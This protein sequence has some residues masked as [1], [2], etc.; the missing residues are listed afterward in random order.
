MVIKSELL[1]ILEIHNFTP[2]HMVLLPS[3]HRPPWNQRKGSLHGS[4]LGP[5]NICYGC[6]SLSSSGTPNRGSGDCLWL[7][8]FLLR[9][10][11]F[12]CVALSSL[13]I[14]GIAYAMFGWYPLEVCSFLK[15]K[16]RGV[17][18]GREEKGWGEIGRRGGRGKFSWDVIYERGVNSKRL[19][20]KEKKM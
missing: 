11:Y 13:D 4:D 8:C 1:N 2:E 5:L 12:Y 9:L 16:G 6:S 14:R 7:F 15:G 18:V 19:K 10:F 17:D 20:K 3:F